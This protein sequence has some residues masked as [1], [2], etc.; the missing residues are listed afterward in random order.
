MKLS[1][2]PSLKF[3]GVALGVFWAAWNLH[4]FWWGLIYGLFW[5]IALGFHATEVFLR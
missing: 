3:T 1:Y 5:P 2:Q 4:G